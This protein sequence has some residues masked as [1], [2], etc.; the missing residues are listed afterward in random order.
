MEPSSKIR[1]GLAVTLLA[2]AAC[3]G[4]EEQPTGAQGGTGAGGAGGGAV[5][6]PACDVH[7][8][9]APTH[10]TDASEAWG[11][12]GV[13]GGSVTA[14]DLN[15]DGFP[16]LIVHHGHANQRELIGGPDR[17]YRVLMNEPRE[18]GGRTFVDRTAESGYGATPE[19][20]TTEYRAAQT[21]ILGD[22][23]ND[24]DLDIFSGVWV[25]PPQSPPTLAD[26]DRSRILLNDG[27]GHFQLAPDSDVQTPGAKRLG[28]VTFVDADRDGSLDLFEGFWFEGASYGIVNQKLL[29]GD[30]TGLFTDVSSEVGIATVA[31]RRPSFGV[32]ACDLDDDGTPE[33]IAGAYGRVPSILYESDAPNHF[34]DIGVASGY[35]YDDNLDYHDDQSYLC[36]CVNHQGDAYCDGAVPPSLSAASCNQVPPW[37]PG[38]SDQPERLAGNT[39]TTACSDLTGDGLLDLYKGQIVHWWAGQASDPPELLVQA[40]GSDGIRFDRPDRDAMGM[41]LP[42]VGASWNEGGLYAAPGD[43]DNDGREDLIVGATDYPDQW[44]LY[45]HQKPDGTFEEIAEASGWHHPCAATPLLVDFDRDGDLDLIVASSQ[46]REW[47]TA[48][49][50][51]G[52]EV[53]LYESD[54][55]QHGHWLVLKLAGDGVSANSAGFGARVRVRSHDEAGQETVQL[56]ELGGGYGHGSMQPD[57]VLFFGLGGCGMVDSIEVTWPDQARTVDLHEDV[58]VDRVIELR[59]GDAEVHAAP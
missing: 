6:A 55:S 51:D 34:A 48:K 59:Q 3:G 24:G 22:V 37:Q 18:G 1:V 43:I 21:S 52:P 36:Y 58:A 7:A 40:G 9:Q 10:F 5:D 26:L 35:A 42:H 57:T 27:S 54:A 47:C 16:D 2:A 13:L 8:S 49:W 23:D 4:S 28:G 19:G 33:L 41:A 12:A 29:R 38:V 50:P 53:R 44:G 15:G 11:L 56:K 45:Y 31:N 30:R 20:S 25:E 32:A 46:M 14:G 17:Y 39:F